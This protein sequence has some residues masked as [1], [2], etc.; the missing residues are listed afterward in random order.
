[1]NWVLAQK[2]PFPEY[3]NF[4]LPSFPK[5]INLSQHSFEEAGQINNSFLGTKSIN[6]LLGYEF[7]RTWE[8][9]DSFSSV[10]KYGDVKELQKLGS[11][12]L[13][14]IAPQAK[15]VE[16]FPYLE[17]VPL[18]KLIKNLGVNTESDAWQSVI[19]LQCHDSRRS[20]TISSCLQTFYPDKTLLDFGAS[21][22]LSEL[23]LDEIPLRHFPDINNF[24]LDNVPGTEKFHLNFSSRA[25]V[26]KLDIPFDS[27]ET[28][29]PAISGS[30]QEQSKTCS[31]NCPHVEI[32]AQNLKPLSMQWIS[33]RQKVK[34]GRGVLGRIN[35]G[36]EPTGRHPFG[37]GF[38]V[39]ISDINTKKGTV[40]TNIYLRICKRTFFVDLG[41]TPYFIGPIPLSV[42]SEED[43]I[44]F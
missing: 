11:K 29:I 16:D 27:D 34:G 5:Y 35:D 37:Y 2:P 43:F 39:V 10:L 13:S 6:D 22:S 3:I 40:R 23:G 7:P 42:V 28:N 1:M 21:G 38:K 12:K 26:G 4:S 17:K 14:E 20:D 41:C 31:E 33:G 30:N 36:R 25:F 15:E 9:G 8:A 32:L 44:F 19:P 18:W 24:S